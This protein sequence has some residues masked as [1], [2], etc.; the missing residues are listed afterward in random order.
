[1][2]AASRPDQCHCRSARIL[3]E[4]P[5]T[6][7][8]RVEPT[9]RARSG[10][11]HLMSTSCGDRPL[12]DAYRGCWAGLIE[13]TCPTHFGVNAARYGQPIGLIQ[14]SSATPHK[15]GA[16]A[17]QGWHQLEMDEV[18]GP[19]FILG[20]WNASVDYLPVVA[21]GVAGDILL[22]DYDVAVIRAHLLD[23]CHVASR[24]NSFLR[25]S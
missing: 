21:V 17:G 22:R 6:V 1:M 3:A 2:S 5:V 16:G 20:G 11:D 19:W 4:P 9:C 15:I 24:G 23:D 18:V 25:V 8:P 10:H 7:N 13:A 14:L 12:L